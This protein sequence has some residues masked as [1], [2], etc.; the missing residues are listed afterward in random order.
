MAIYTSSDELSETF[1]GFIREM[2]AHPRRA[3]A[4]QVLTGQPKQKIDID[5]SK[6][7][8]A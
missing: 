8:H 2:A 3:I 5:N 4:H 7:Q 6:V 1:T